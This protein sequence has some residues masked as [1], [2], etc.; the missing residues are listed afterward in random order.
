MENGNKLI[1]IKKPS[2]VRTASKWEH[3]DLMR[4]CVDPK[5][6]LFSKE[7][8]CD[9]ILHSGGLLITPHKYSGSQFIKGFSFL[10]LER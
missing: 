3:W 7:K 1:E 5:P 6:V 10:N 8:Q 4:I 9:Y 2:D